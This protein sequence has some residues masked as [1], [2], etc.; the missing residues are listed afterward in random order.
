ML[1]LSPQQHVGFLR[2]C[3]GGGMWN[4]E[5]KSTEQGKTSLPQDQ[6]SCWPISSLH[7][8]KCKYG[9]ARMMAYKRGTIFCSI[10][11]LEHGWSN[12]LLKEK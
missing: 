5:R 7:L 3:S 8:H 12:Y 9:R 2:G 11:G 1:P 6:D 10:L 4:G